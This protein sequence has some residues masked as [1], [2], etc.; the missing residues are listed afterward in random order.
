MFVVGFNG[1]PECGKDTM[2]EMLADKMDQQGVTLP[3]RMESL[4][5][6][7]RQIAYQMVGWPSDSLDGEQYAVFKTTWFPEFERYG[8]QIMI[9]ISERF[10]KPVYGIEVMA[11]M[12]LTRNENFHGILLVRDCGFQIEVDPIA[13]AIGAKNLY[14]AQVHR[15]GKDFSND[16][17]EWVYNPDG[18]FMRVDNNSDLEH[19]RTEAGRLYGRLVNQM[20]W[21]L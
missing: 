3:V 7:L 17:R 14:L 4:S 20:G 6:P 16:S 13:K 12:L 1:P 2:A 11:K 10:L 18:G 21:V 9:D 19:L 15:P 5:M 8:R